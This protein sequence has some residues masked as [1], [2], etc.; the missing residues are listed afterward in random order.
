MSDLHRT[1]LQ[2]IQVSED[3]EIHISLVSSPGSPVFI[4]I[5]NYIPSLDYYGRGMILPPGTPKLI[6]AALNSAVRQQFAS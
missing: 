2:Q 4:E 6:A 3:L 5:R 1:L